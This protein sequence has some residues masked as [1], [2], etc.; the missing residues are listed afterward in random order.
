MSDLET[1]RLTEAAAWRV[2]LAEKIIER[3]GV[4]ETFADALRRFRTWIANGCARGF[5]ATMTIA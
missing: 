4:P 2:R 3:E 1:S 5:D